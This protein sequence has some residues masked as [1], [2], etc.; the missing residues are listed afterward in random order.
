MRM[1][2]KLLQ[3]LIADD[4]A[5]LRR[6]IA[7]LIAADAAHCHVCGEAA[8][9][10]EALRLAAEL[11]PDAVL[12]DLSIPQLQGLE[13]AKRLNAM[14]PGIAIVILSE[15]DPRAL[16]FLADAAGLRYCVAKSRLTTDL[17]PTLR[18]IADQLTDG[19]A[20][21]GTEPPSGA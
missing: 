12:L 18:E 2:M 16:R 7:E 11:R 13:V 19:R 17:S 3:V 10:E 6:A 20:A 21:R 15:Q 4:S 1:Q 9:G 5:P 8:D 14:H